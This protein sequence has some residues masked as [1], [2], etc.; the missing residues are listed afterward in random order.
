MHPTRIFERPEQLEKAFEE[1][2]EDLVN[3]SKEWLKV[4]YVGKDGYRAADPMKVPM[5]MEGFKRYCRK[6]YGDVVQY[7]S[8]TDNYYNDFT[9]ICS[10]IKDEIRENQIVGGML[11]VFNV[12]ITQRLNGLVEKQETIIK[13]QPLFPDETK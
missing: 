6:N 10:Q 7:F 8:N 11:G 5:T 3:Q 4:Q 2:K 1:Y 12:S 13:E 9:S